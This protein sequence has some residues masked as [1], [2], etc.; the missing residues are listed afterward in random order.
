[1][2]IVLE[3]TLEHMAA[4]DNSTH[5]SFGPICDGGMTA[6][7]RLDV[8]VRPI[9]DIRTSFIGKPCRIVVE[10]DEPDAPR[11]IAIGDPHST[12]FG[13]SC[14]EIHIDSSRQSHMVN[15]SQG[16]V[17]IS[18]LSGESAAD[19]ILAV[20]ARDD[21]PSPSGH[22]Y[23]NSAAPPPNLSTYMFVHP[24]G[25]EGAK[26]LNAIDPIDR[27]HAA[28]AKYDCVM[29]PS[30]RIDECII[31]RRCATQNLD[32]VTVSLDDI[33]RAMTDPEDSAMD[34]ASRLVA[35]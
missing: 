32:S 9:H 16:G 2:R 7:L 3:S 10:F 20:A 11:L 13:E 4:S 6:G 1:M 35:S 8:N 22:C 15:V 14:G 12:T 25:R 23:G 17:H 24:E 21:G 29:I 26:S 33:S 19:R 18:D 31:R 28:L 30:G 27:F 34:F 5:L